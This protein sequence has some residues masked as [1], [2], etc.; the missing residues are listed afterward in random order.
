MIKKFTLLLMV[1]LC[2]VQPS[3]ASDDYVGT[4]RTSGNEGTTVENNAVIKLEANDL[5]IYKAT[6][7]N[8]T[9]QLM[10]EVMNLGTMEYTNMMGIPD[11]DDDDYLTIKGNKQVNLMDHLDDA[12]ELL[13]MFPEEYR[14]LL[15]M[16]MGANF[17]ISMNARFSDTNMTAHFECRVTISVMGMF[18]LLDETVTKEFT[19][20]CDRPAPDPDPALYLLGSFNGWNENEMV[21]LTLGANGKWTVTQAM[22]A[23]AEF[24]LKDEQG[25]WLGAVSDGNF[26]V[27]Q[28]QVAEQTPLT[29][30]IPGM[31][32]QIPVAGEWT[33]TVDKENMMVVIGGNWMEP[34]DV[35]G[36]VTGDS[37]VDV[38]DVNAAINIILGNKTSQDYPG[39]ADLTG[40]G[41]VDVSDVNAIINIILNAD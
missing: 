11:E 17:P 13:E 19:G 9:L 8:F 39:N 1:M 12:S 5:G 25:N 30:S 35:V 23:N 36:D 14:G 10:G 3:L 29:L 20:V 34:Q 38:S 41:T 31:N 22:D 40:D 15:V 6:I 27:T 4:M 16:S 28:E 26:I 37:T 18:T 24:K 7:E 2:A 32:F 33:L 21:P